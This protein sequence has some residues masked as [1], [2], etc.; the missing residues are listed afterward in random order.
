M[1][2][3]RVRGEK[4][5]LTMTNCADSH[6]I[7]LR[8]LV[9]LYLIAIAKRRLRVP[10]LAARNLLNYVQYRNDASN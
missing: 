5:G 2:E 9:Y 1:A 7:R 10:S 3:K 8:H 4:I 6:H